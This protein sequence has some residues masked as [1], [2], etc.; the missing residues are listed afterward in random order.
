MTAPPLSPVSLSLH[1]FQPR[2]SLRRRQL[3]RFFFSRLW[4]SPL[5]L[6]LSVVFGSLRRLQ[7]WRSLALCLAVDMQLT[8]PTGLLHRLCTVNASGRF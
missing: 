7:L 5:S 6:V 1:R 3:P 2:S 4:L 8:A